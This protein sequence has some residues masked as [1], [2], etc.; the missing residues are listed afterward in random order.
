MTFGV[1]DKSLMGTTSIPAGW[2]ADTR[3]PRQGGQATVLHVRD[4]RG[5]EGVY[6]ELKG[7]VTAKARE[8]FHREVGILPRAGSFS[9]GPLFAS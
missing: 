3:T 8:R 2:V 1:M 6:R 5:R 9:T 7:R 4:S